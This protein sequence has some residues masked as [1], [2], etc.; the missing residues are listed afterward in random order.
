MQRDYALAVCNL[1]GGHDGFVQNAGMQK[2]LLHHNHLISKTLSIVES[3]N[4]LS[5]IHS[6]LQVLKHPMA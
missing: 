3:W 5:F 2:R 4:A 1:H 6:P